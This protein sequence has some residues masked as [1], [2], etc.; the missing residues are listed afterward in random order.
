MLEHDSEIGRSIIERYF[1]CKDRDWKYENEWRYLFDHVGSHGAMAVVSGIYF[2]YKASPALKSVLVKLITS[3][4][5][6][7]Y[8]MVRKHGS[9]NFERKLINADEVRHSATRTEKHHD[10]PNYE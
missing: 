7:F 10:F 9:Y 8:N 1:F 4:K 5:I 6:S 3:S 2:G